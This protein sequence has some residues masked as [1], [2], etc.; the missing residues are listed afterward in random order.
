MS[1][2]KIS[3]LTI[4]DMPI[5]HSGV[6]H[7]MK[8]IIESLLKTGKYKVISL[9]GAISHANYAPIKTEEFGDDWI[10]IPVDH[11]GTPEIVRAQIK[12]NKIDQVLIM[13][14]PRFFKDW[15][16]PM[17]QE[18]RRQCSF[19]YYT[20]WDNFPTPKFNKGYYDSFDLLVPISK[21]TDKVIE[22]LSPDIKRIRIPHAVNPEIFKK[23]P[24]EVVSNF[25]KENFDS[26]SPGN[27][28]KFLFFFNGRNARRKMTGSLIFW[29]NEFLNQVGKDK[30]SLL[31]H[32]NPLDPNGQNLQAIIE[33][34]GL[35]NGEVLFSVEQVPQE[36]LTLMYN[37]AD[38]FVLLSDA[39]GWGIPISEAL[40]CE[41]PV[42]ATYTG[43][44]KD[45][46][47]DGKDVFG[48]SIN[49]SSQ[50]IIGGQDVP[51]IY[52]D[53][54]NEDDVV[55]AMKKMYNMT[56]NERAELGRKGHE[57][58]NKECNY[59]K[60]CETWVKT[61][62]DCYEENGSWETRKNYKN[63]YFKTF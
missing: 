44:I 17:D 26:L 3:L 7:Q 36:V 12:M 5:S 21:T 46:I 50:A 60:F 43:G 53:R 24:D 38:A 20:I 25:R 1:E 59:D 4:S 55:A 22:E 13:T 14:D 11:F 41:T 2:K 8:L 34:L 56:P 39:E 6:A 48:V 23:L 15:L 18:I 58:L 57:H 35:V 28:K 33:D 10:M 49:P 32:T 27:D 9:G 51:Y 47:T 19:I 31:M 61:M 16:I 42:I 29:F 30:A 37:A 62:L 52:E 63:Y 45:Q 54:I 40:A